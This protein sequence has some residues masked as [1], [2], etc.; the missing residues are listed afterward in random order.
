[1][2]KVCLTPRGLLIMAVGVLRLAVVL[3]PAEVGVPP[4]RSLR[5]PYLVGVGVVVVVDDVGLFSGT[6]SGDR[7]L[8]SVPPPLR[9]S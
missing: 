3:L 9:P 1:M 2:T 6:L 5:L 8:L 7:G 4:P